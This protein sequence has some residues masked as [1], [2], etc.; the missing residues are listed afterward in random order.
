MLV[1]ACAAAIATIE[2]LLLN[3][4]RRL[5][6]LDPRR[7]RLFGRH[8]RSPVNSFNQEKQP[9]AGAAG[10]VGNPAPPL[11]D[12]SPRAD[13]ATPAAVDHSQPPVSQPPEI[14]LLYV[15][16]E[17]RCTAGNEAARLLLHGHEEEDRLSDVLSGSGE[18]IAAL[19]DRVALEAVVES[20]PAVLGRPY[21]VPVEIDAIALRDRDSNFWGTALF[22]RM[23]RAAVIGEDSTAERSPQLSSTPPLR[24]A[25][26]RPS[27]RV[28]W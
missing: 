14:S 1:S 15:D 24:V 9:A 2:L 6:M 12:Q 11:S 27:G 20:Y 3:R 23:R 4:Q 25:S 7:R 22:V 19:L 26:A 10:Q 5:L 18:D 28:P 8:L 21:A 17:G 13:A 16:S